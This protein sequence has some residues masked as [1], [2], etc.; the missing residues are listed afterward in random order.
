[1]KGVPRGVW[2]LGVVSLLMDV[3][4]EM[5]HVLLPL[6][7]VGVMGTSVLAVGVIEGIAAATAAFAKVFSGALSDW[8]GRRKPLA[9]AGYGLAAL[10]KP[11]FAMAPSLGW[12]VAARFV[13]RLGKGIRGAPRDALIA[14]M[15]PPES[16]GAAYGLRQ[17]LDMVGGFAGPLLAM[18]LIGWWGDFQ[19]VFWVAVIPA[20][21]SVAVL[22]AFV[23]EPAQPAP[24][25]ARMPLNRADMARL[26]RRYWAVVG[27]AALFTM[28]R[29]SEAFL[30]LLAGPAGLPLA[31][32]PLVA[33]VMA[34]SYAASAWPVGVLADRMNRHAL[35]GLGIAVLIAAN[36][37]LAFV[38]GLWGLGIGVALWGLHL[39]MTQGLLA[40][41]VADTVP[42]DL[43]GTGFGLFN[44]ISGLALLAASLLAGLIWDRF[45]PDAMLLSSAG[46]A[47]LALTGWSLRGARK[48]GGA[49]WPK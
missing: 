40:A 25:P 39:G 20:A 33:V 8:M 24:R 23:R 46:L 11:L 4:S 47:F 16:R 1:M 43:R 36:L 7:M 27:L 34:A 30:I 35:L 32:A 29:F 15:T 12:L 9:V 44:L 2:A 49:G 14:D 17:S 18:V 3:S 31:M 38:P 13:D 28:A 42:P 48:A 10:T 37:V 26:D 41:M 5:I 6:Y 45:G 21:L 22:L 19:A